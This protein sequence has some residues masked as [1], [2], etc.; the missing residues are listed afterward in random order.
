MKNT[1]DNFW[2]GWL[3]MIAGIFLP[4][5]VMADEVK[6]TDSNGNELRYFFDSADSPATFTGRWFA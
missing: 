1:K 2:R 5:S 3:L 6:V 4:L